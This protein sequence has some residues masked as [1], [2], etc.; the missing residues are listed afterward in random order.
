MEIDEKKFK[1]ILE[2]QRKEYQNYLGVVAE[3]FKSQVKLL[4]E[5]VSGIQEQL[6][7][8]R[9]MVAQNTKDM[10]I[11]KVE[12]MTIKSDI[13]IIKN[14]LKRKVGHDEFEAL[15]KRVSFLEKAR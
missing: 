1:N 7:A 3:D 10:E 15:E 8:L 12:M 9:E 11:I 6:I 13:E 4:V 14:D 2:D 5:S